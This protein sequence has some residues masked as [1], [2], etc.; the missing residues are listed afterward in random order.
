MSVA[1]YDRWPKR[2]VV[3]K[4][5]V[6]GLADEVKLLEARRVMLLTD[7]GLASLPFIDEIGGMLRKAGLIVCLFSEIQPHPTDDNAYAA[8]AKAREFRAEVL[9]SVGGGSAMDCTRATK[10]LIAYGGNIRDHDVHNRKFTYQRAD[11]LP[12]IA[13]PTTAG[14]GSEVAGGVGLYGTDPLTGETMEI[15]IADAALVPDVALLDPVLTVSLPAYPTAFSGMDVLVHAVESIFSVNHFAIS[16]GLAVQAIKMV[17]GNL[18]T[19][20][21]EPGNLPARE[22]MM[23][24]ATTATMAFGQTMLGLCHSMAMSL[25]VMA[26]IPHGTANAIL[27][28]GVYRLNAKAAPERAVM[29]AGAMGIEG[30]NDEE[31]IEA[32]AT[33]FTQL[34]ED[35]GLPVWL[36]DTGFTGEMVPKAAQLAKDCFFTQMNPVKPGTEEIGEMYRALFK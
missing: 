9:V 34:L 7:S 13:V 24:A 17:Q 23:V 30:A 29:I 35:I 3:G 27:L 2:L 8:A 12:H 25:S 22:A 6:K 14:T 10:A 18:R 16:D 11:M 26:G 20:V 19:A 21:K 36:N 5:A 31:A 15:S 1:V 32:T 28:P 33:A 4:D